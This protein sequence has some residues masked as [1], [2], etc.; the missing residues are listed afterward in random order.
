MVKSGAN[1]WV[2]DKSRSNHI[3][4]AWS[5]N[6]VCGFFGKEEPTM[7]L[8]IGTS[9]MNKICH[10]HEEYEWEDQSENSHFERPKNNFLVGM[11]LQGIYIL[12]NLAMYKYK[13]SI[14]NLELTLHSY[15]IYMLHE[16]INWGLKWEN[17]H[18]DDQTNFCLYT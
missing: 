11:H 10:V 8:W 16:K 12:I 15:T 14:Y 13:N 7:E 3:Y 2:H 5:P 17:T 4:F 18:F 6:W 9:F 1:A